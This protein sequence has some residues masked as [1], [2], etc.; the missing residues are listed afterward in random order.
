MTDTPTTP[1]FSVTDNAAKRIA[2]L[3]TKESEPNSFLRIEVEGGGCSG[4][5]YKFNFDTNSQDDDFVIHQ[6]D[7]TVAINPMSLELVQGSVLDYVESL[8]ASHFEIKNPNASAQCGCGN[9][10]AV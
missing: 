5:Q 8:G 7:A 3:A 9:S 10:F 1:A 2:F 4:F 6:N